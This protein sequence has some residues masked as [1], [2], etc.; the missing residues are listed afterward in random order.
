MA[1]TNP[2]TTR[3][4]F[5]TRTTT[6]LAGLGAAGLIHRNLFASG[7]DAAPAVPITRE[8]LEAYSTWLFYER[9]L[10]SMEL[11]PDLGLQAEGFLPRA[12][13]RIGSWHFPS[14]DR[15]QRPHPSTRAVAILSAAGVPLTGKTGR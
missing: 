4:G 12:G 7:A 8:M 3:R 1:E 9:R 14:Q 6:A 15:A 10:L 11:Y 13:S 5:L 2:S